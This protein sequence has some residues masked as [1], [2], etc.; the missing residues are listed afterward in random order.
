[1]AKS[2]NPDNSIGLVGLVVIAV[3]LTGFALSMAAYEQPADEKQYEL[4][5]EDVDT[6]SVS[7][8]YTTS[9]LS[10][11]DRSKVQEMSEDGEIT[12]KNPPE[13]SKLVD[14]EDEVVSVVTEDGEEVRFYVEDTTPFKWSILAAILFS[15]LATSVGF[16][17]SHE[18]EEPTAL[19]GAIVIVAVI[20]LI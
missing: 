1:M 8:V 16:I 19:L 10:E 9:E 2:I 15:L 12:L 18:A 13:N 11:Y 5:K 17:Y 20:C 6:G 14:S 7:T 4:N 3:L